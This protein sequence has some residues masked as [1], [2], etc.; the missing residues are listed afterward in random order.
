MRSKISL[1]DLLEANILSPNTTLVW[2]RRKVTHTAKL[3]ATGRI[4][5]ATGESFEAPSGACRRLNNN[6]S[7]DGWLVWRV[8]DSSG[9]RLDELRK[10][11]RSS[12]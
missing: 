3:S 2:P 10:K 1:A 8:G 12:K 6:L 9:P 11:L 4:E 7:V 5:L